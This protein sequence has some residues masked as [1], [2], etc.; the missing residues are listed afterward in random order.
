MKPS[1]VT[2]RAGPLLRRCAE[3]SSRGSPLAPVYQRIAFK[4]LH[5]QQLGLGPSVIARK[6]GVDRKTVGK[7]LAWLD[8]MDEPAACVI[9]GLPA[10]G[11]PI[12]KTEVPAHETV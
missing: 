11:G 10:R 8:K 7:A 5:L 4:T 3:R 6:L 12:H 1:P 9:R 2:P